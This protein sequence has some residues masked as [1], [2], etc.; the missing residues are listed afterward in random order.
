MGWLSALMGMGS[1]TGGKGL[2][3]ALGGGG[4]PAQPHVIQPGAGLLQHLF[5]QLAQT[6][7]VTQPANPP[8][9]AAT[10]PRLDTPG[11][12][13]D[14]IAI[15]NEAAAQTPGY[16]VRLKSGFRPGDPRFHGKHKA[17]DVTLFKDGKPLK[18]YQNPATFSDYERFAKTARAVQ[19]AKFPNRADNFRW[20]GY[21]SGGPKTYGAL[22]L[23][24]FDMGGGPGVGMVGGSWDTGLTPKQAA[25]W[26]LQPGGG[27]IT[28][29]AGPMPSGG[30]PTPILRARAAIQSIE[31]GGN[32][33]VM[34][35]VT[36]SGDRAYG[37]YQVMGKN[38]GPWTKEAFGRAMT[39]EEFLKSPQVQ[40]ALFDY[41]FG[42]LMD[43]YGPEGASLAWFT[44]SPEGTRDR[45]DQLGTSGS[46]YAAKF[47]AAFG[48]PKLKIPA[49][50]GGSP[51]SGGGGGGFDGISHPNDPFGVLTAQQK[52]RGG[53]GGGEMAADTSS[54]DGLS[55]LP[56]EDRRAKLE[57]LR[58]F[59]KLG[60]FSDGQI[61]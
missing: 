40:D 6:Q 11:V 7:P 41:Q 34:G 1:P 4:L 35:P 27:G 53:G 25:I 23:M 24:H 12:D 52:R 30:A 56:V 15:L 50:G 37:A 48:D 10:A 33:G 20:G 47:M 36:S 21:F 17:M 3:G 32:Y 28:P 5:P 51:M 14:L 49:F 9:R 29:A 58:M 46:D 38:I 16:E 61:V 26:G 31:S 45:Q 60:G 13:P 57:K 43:H 54:E 2:L 39:P 55:P 19:M 22:D 8:P 59:L 18:D 42:R 44:G